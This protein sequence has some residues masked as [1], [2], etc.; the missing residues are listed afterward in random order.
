MSELRWSA[1]QA[2]WYRFD[3]VMAE[4][5]FLGPDLTRDDPY[6]LSAVWLQASGSPDLLLPEDQRAAGVRLEWA[7]VAESA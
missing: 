1:P 4:P 6:D 2:G 3:S 5:E 7:E